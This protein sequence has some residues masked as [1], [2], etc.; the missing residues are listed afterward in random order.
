MS[1]VKYFVLTKPKEEK[2]D[3]N[4]ENQIITLSEKVNV[5][6]LPENNLEYY[7]KNGLFEKSLIEWCKQFCSKDKVFLDIGA[8]TG[9]YSISLSE[10]SK[11][12]YSFEPQRMTYYSLCGSVALSNI[13]N[14]ECI[15]C[16]LGSPEQI[17]KKTLNIVSVDGGGSS[18]HAENLRFSAPFPSNDGFVPYTEEIEVKTL[19]SFKIKEEIG[20]IK[21]DV[22]ENEL[23]VLQGSQETLKLNNY[24]KIIFES[25]H[26]NKKLMDYV[27]NMGYRIIQLNGVSN[28]YLA[29]INYTDRK[30]K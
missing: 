25:N 28:M 29:T 24:P 13:K 5:Y 19:D 30:E 14:I 9:T 22:E 15:N 21:M 11:K 20:F 12:V 16:G 10:K 1:L 8:H 6:I 23:Y 3:K 2:I 17:G 4:N 7:N 18:I 27:K 26:E